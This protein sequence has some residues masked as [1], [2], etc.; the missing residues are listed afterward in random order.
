M[1]PEHHR[2]STGGGLLA[3]LLWSTTFGFARSLSE[4]VGAV[5]GGAAVYLAG[6]LFCVLRLMSQPGRLKY[7]LNSP[8]RYLLGCGALFVAYTVF[9][10]LA[11]GFARDRAQLLEIA[12]VNYLWPAA[13]VVLSLPLLGQRA[14]VLLLPGT[15]LALA[16]I[17]LVMTQGAHA[18]GA[19]FAARFVG[20]PVAYL[21]ALAA[22]VSWALYSNLARRWAVNGGPGGVVLFIPATG[23]ILLLIRVGWN[24]PGD[25]SPRALLEAGALGVVTLLGYSLWDGAMRKGNLLLVAVCSY[26]TPLLSTLASSIY[27]NTIPGTEVWIGSVCLVAGSV[28][29]WRSVAGRHGVSARAR[30]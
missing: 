28:I 10:Y 26:F 7:L 9:I 1:S 2:P 25:W 12:L 3:I 18:D 27:L 20:N 14:N 16:G 8:R 15:L 24:E 23:L 11:I 19:S 30:T 5:T 17:F 13:T 29:S 4:Q 21:L 22:A 6:G